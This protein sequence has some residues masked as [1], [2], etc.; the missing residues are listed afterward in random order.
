MSYTERWP[1][2][3][4]TRLSRTAVWDMV[5]LAANG[6]IFVLLGGQLPALLAAAPEIAQASLQR[7]AVWLAVLAAVMLVAL[8]LLR[9]LWVGA[10]LGLRRALARRAGGEMPAGGARTVAVMTLA[11]V[12]G[13]VTLAGV[14]TLPLALGDG[15]PFPG[16]E[17][18][19]LLAAGVSVGSL[20]LA[21]VALPWV[22]RGFVLPAEPPQSDAERAARRAA[23]RAALAAVGAAQGALRDGATG[24][25]ADVAARIVA[26]YE[27]RL[28]HHDAADA[29]P[30]DGE[31]DDIERQL[32]LAGLDAERAEV[33]KIRRAHGIDD[34][35]LR[36]LVREIDHQE[37][38]FR[39]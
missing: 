18:A 14:L 26:I 12:R 1:W 22:L 35:S 34:L 28:A 32:R 24:R 23:A 38:R 19:I 3:A 2:A 30:E 5:Q 15:R 16:R 27:L 4:S 10:S 31:D 17:L 37:A 6:S 21:A 25:G 7:P 9:A 8:A 36:R 33:R 11:G 20:L 39:R 13:A 29:S